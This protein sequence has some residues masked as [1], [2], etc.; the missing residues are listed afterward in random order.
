M[1]VILDNIRSVYNVGAI[2]RTADAVGVS[3]ACLCGI[4]PEPVDKWG[5]TRTDF[6]KVS[7]GAEDY[8]LWKTYSSTVRLIGKLKKTGYIILA[9]EQARNS[10]PYYDVHLTETELQQ[11]ALVVGSEIRGLPKSILKKAD[12]ILEIPMFG[13]KESLNVAIAFGIVSFGLV[14]NNKRGGH[15]FQKKRYNN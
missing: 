6:T 11:T 10:K 8:I 5:K 13:K 9:I 14:A 1:I 15:C 4:T 12:E 7:L 2:F 3:E